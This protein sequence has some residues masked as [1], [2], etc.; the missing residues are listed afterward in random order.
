M[1]T[2]HLVAGT[3]SR[4][5]EHRLSSKT[6]KAKQLAF[7]HFSLVQPPKVT[8]IFRMRVKNCP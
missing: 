8:R 6:K 2:A 1:S 7:L 3:P 5:F 4:F